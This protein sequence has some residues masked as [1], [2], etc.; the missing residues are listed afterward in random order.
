MSRASERRARVSRQI[1]SRNT[2][3]L[4][5]FEPFR[6]HPLIRGGHLQTF[7]TTLVK[8]PKTNLT[9]L[10][11][12]VDLED[13]DQLVVHDDHPKSWVPGNLVVVLI[14]GLGGCHRAGYMLRIAQ[15]LH[16]LG[17]RTFR[18]DMRGAG[19]GWGLAA[20][21]NHAGRSEDIQKI[22]QYAH[23]Q[24]PQSPIAVIGVSLGG[25]QLLKLLG[26]WGE[27]LYDRDS[28]LENI[29]TAVSV[30]PP[31]D[32]IH[33][34]NNMQRWIMKPYNQYFIRSLFRNIPARVQESEA[35]QRLKLDRRPSSLFELDDVIT[36]PLSGFNGA[37]DYYKKSSSIHRLSAIQV[38][39]LVITAKD[40][41][42]VPVSSF[43]KADWSEQTTIEITAG[44][45][46]V[47]YLAAPKKRHW[48]DRRIE[49]WLRPH[50]SKSQPQSGAGTRLTELK[51]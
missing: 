26:E 27:G 44:G 23:R 32:L 22:I 8:P 9:P 14:H 7:V 16:D 25:N 48:L 37:M 47:G 3:E 40:D 28:G 45:G 35:F 4:T 19:D 42:I 18:A 30:A 46:H 49:H 12:R 6:P 50:I 39:T 21:L 20:K 36:A 11:H 41:P 17:V 51:T 31:I 33:C 1:V 38:P 29:V 10:P 5:L 24:A 15:R 2:D 43:S 13:G 34:S